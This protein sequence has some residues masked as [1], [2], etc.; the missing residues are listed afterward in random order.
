M[1]NARLEEL[2]SKFQENPRRYF[3]PYANELRKTGDAAQAISVCRAHLTIQPGHVSGHIVLGQALYEAGAAP[4]ARDVFMTALDLDPENLI[5]LRTLG[6]IAQ[7]NGEFGSARQWYERLLEADPRN[8]E[9]SQL[10]RD[11]PESGVVAQEHVSAVETTVEEFAA[12]PRQD[13]SQSTAEIPGPTF[14]SGF[15]GPGPAYRTEADLA[16]SSGNGSVLDPSPTEAHAHDEPVPFVD[17]DAS[18]FDEPRA[19]QPEPTGPESWR[20]PPP[21]YVADVPAPDEPSLETV[22]STPPD[23]TDSVEM[24]DLGAFEVS[25]LE[26]VAGGASEPDDATSVAPIAS[27]ADVD[28]SFDLASEDD[29]SAGDSTTD[30]RNVIAAETSAE[31][32]ASADESEAPA[33]DQ[34]HA[35]FAE[36]GFD[37][38]AVDD[39]VGW[40]ITPSVAQSDPE[41]APE[42]WYEVPEVE[43]PVEVAAAPEPEPVVESSGSETAK[44]S[45]F[46][47]AH[48]AMP[49]AHSDVTADE[50]WLPPDLSRVAATGSE[51]PK[52]ELE[53]ESEVSDVSASVSVPSNGDA[54]A[55]ILAESNAMDSRVVDLDG[56][57][58]PELVVTEPSSIQPVEAGELDGA[59]DS[60]WSEPTVTPL[61]SSPESAERWD[62]AR[63]QQEQIADIVAEYGDPAEA[64]EYAASVSPDEPAYPGPVVGHTPPL[65]ES[66]L[67]ESS[68]PFITETLAEL[69]LQQGFRD[70]ALSIY[71]QLAERDPGNQSLR[72]RVEAIEHGPVVEQVVEP[73]VA[74]A[75]AASQSVRTF[76]SQIARR[77]AAGRRDNQSQADPQASAAEVPFASAVSALSN[78]FAAAKPA[79]ADEGRASSLANAFTDPA[80][81]PTRAAER[82]L[83]LDHLFRDVP[84]GSTAGGMT[85]DEFYSTP[86][87]TSNSSTESGEASEPPES[88]GTSGADIR[89]FTAWLEGLRKK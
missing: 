38:P 6:E 8:G 16:E 89:Q 73:A 50:F 69:Y 39:Q 54:D 78:L 22:D 57:S 5:A 65:G 13:E 60:Q 67:P 28:L 47:D 76:F 48:E 84:P 74:E 26:T 30:L 88:G 71:R 79:E 18:E 80:G 51:V 44:D 20:S 29:D 61:G 37:G 58:E 72:D 24:V 7:V 3:A 77:P 85:L 41:A 31:I 81:R 53:N 1:M 43:A 19:V 10:L 4:E 23:Q 52:S 14:H 36:R 33:T 11:L 12:E 82:E 63:E 55:P 2:R 15:T 34:S 87:A 35:S 40:V 42:D 64:T 83:S 66:A 21:S 49:P 45:W 9:V 59:D 70:E 25:T 68:T 27:T 17:M 46:E 62:N 56:P 75:R 86:D 32:E